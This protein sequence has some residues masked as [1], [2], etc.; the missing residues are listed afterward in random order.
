MYLARSTRQ[1]TSFT[2][3]P[4]LPM[5]LVLPSI[6]PDPLVLYAYFFSFFLFGQASRY[7]IF[8]WPCAEVEKLEN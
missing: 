4:L 5:I 6:T 7:N 1:A 8:S 3:Q 2:L